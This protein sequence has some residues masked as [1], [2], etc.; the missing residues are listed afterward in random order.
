MLGVAT[1]IVVNSVMSGFSTKL[2]DSLHGRTSDVLL[3]ARTYDGF[4]DAEDKMNRIKESPAGKYIAAMASTVEVFAMMQVRYHAG[5]K[6]EIINRPVHLVGI[7]PKTQTL[8]GGFAEYLTTG[9]PGDPVPP[10]NFNLPLDGQLRY[11]RAHPPGLEPR[12]P[13]WDFDG[14]TIPPPDLPIEEPKMP[15]GV[16][17]GI[18]TVSYR[19]KKEKPTDEPRD[20][21]FAEPGDEVVLM[22]VTAGKVA[23]V[24]D[25]FVVTSYFKSGMSEYDSNYV[26]VPLDYLQHLRAMDGRVTSIQIKLTDYSH[27][28]EVTEELKRLFPTSLYQVATWEEKQG[29]L[30]GAIAIERGILNILLLLILCVAGFGILSIFSMIVVEKTRD[31]GILKALGASNRGVMSIF[32]CYG[33]LLG[34]VGA[35]LGTILGLTITRHINEFEKLITRLTGHE[36]FDRTIYYFK[37]IPTHIDL[38]SIVLVFVGAVGIAVISSVIP[39]LRAAWLHPVRALRFE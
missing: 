30:L 19:E 36:V 34:T 22:T 35:G 5:F 14:P 16:I 2:R 9:K 24:Y 31:I 21:F 25:R 12:T 28:K 1:L 26:F 7:D 15:H 8:I 17:P 10:T 18:A 4:P 23:P 29:P 6:E 39:A 33:L 37:E 27:A 32:L 20:V 11:V 13:Q 38:S 3:E